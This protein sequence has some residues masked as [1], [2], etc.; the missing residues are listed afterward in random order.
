MMFLYAVALASLSLVGAQDEL[1]T[2]DTVVALSSAGLGDEAIVEKIRAS[3]SD[4]DTSTAAMLNLRQR[5]VSGPVIAA[6]P[7]A[8]NPKPVAAALSVNDPDPM[9][10][11]AAGVY[12]FQDQDG[13]PRMARIDAVQTNQ[14]KTGGFIGYAL[15]GGIASMSVKAAIQNDSAKVRTAMRRPTF[16]FFF[17][18]SNT[19]ATPIAGTWA[20]GTAATVTAPS[21]FTLVE[22]NKKKGRREAR[23]GSL[24]IGG[25]KTGVM[26]KDRL[27]FDYEMVRPGVYRVQPRSDLD[28]GEYGFMYAIAGGG[29]AG[30]MTARMF[31]FGVN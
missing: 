12:L 15:T 5:G 11:H 16:Y 21:E 6:M 19:V 8:D 31:D 23:V 14:A 17:D 22:L 18:E 29:S 2:N 20:S 25:A 26:D 10:P 3:K 27:A 28:A 7:S 24:N 9:V 13:T 30:A 1:L 4:F